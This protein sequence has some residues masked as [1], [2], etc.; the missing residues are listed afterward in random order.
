MK[1]EKNIKKLFLRNDI[2]FIAAIL[3]VAAVG[4]LYLF[5]F[6][7][8]GDTVRVT[9]DGELYGIYS[10]SDDITEDIITGAEGSNLNRLIISDGKVYIE[11]ASC[12]DGICVAHKPIF[13][14]GESIV[15]LPNKVVVT[16]FT[17]K[18]LSSPDIVA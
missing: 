6:R 12:P 4:L 5:G 14:N 2:I 15:C 18:D 1:E 9:V 11:T 10:L 7:R 8:E 17:E 13:R 3:L 16:V